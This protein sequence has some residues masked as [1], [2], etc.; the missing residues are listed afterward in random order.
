MGHQGL[1]WLVAK[2][3]PAIIA[4]YLNFATAARGGLGQEIWTEL[5]T[6]NLVAIAAPAADTLRAQ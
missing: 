2:L 1:S 5:R 6:Q 3:R 4:K